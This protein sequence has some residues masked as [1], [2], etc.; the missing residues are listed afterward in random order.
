MLC[1]VTRADGSLRSHLV[2]QHSAA[3]CIGSDPSVDSAWQSG[4]TCDPCRRGTQPFGP[5]RVTL[6]YT[7]TS[8]ATSRGWFHYEAHGQTTSLMCTQRH[9]SVDWNK[10]AVR[11]QT[12]YCR[13]FRRQRGGETFRYKQHLNN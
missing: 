2:F 1:A 8:A 9:R 4:N 7:T 13:S 6:D 10:I 3:T 11:Q 5:S 12:F